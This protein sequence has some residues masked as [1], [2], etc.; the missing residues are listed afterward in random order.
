MHICRK[1][2]IP[3]SYCHIPSISPSFIGPGSFRSPDVR[4]G[5]KTLNSSNHA[6]HKGRKQF[7]S[8]FLSVA[9]LKEP[10]PS[11]NII[12]PSLKWGWYWHNTVIFGWWQWEGIKAVVLLKPGVCL[13]NVSSV[14]GV[15]L[16]IAFPWCLFCY[17]VGVV[18]LILLHYAVSFILPHFQT[19]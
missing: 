7:W 11:L 12:G 1:I 14:V 2:G 13:G 6:T 5:R 10:F 15:I 17:V 18:I 3:I 4:A 9:S 19:F 16:H 8:Y